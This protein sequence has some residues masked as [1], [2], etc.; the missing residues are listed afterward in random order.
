MLAIKFYNEE[1]KASYIVKANPKYLNTIIFDAGVHLKIP[2]LDI[3]DVPD[4]L[5][6]WRT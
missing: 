2:I 4:T 5:P 6:P 1:K 3:T